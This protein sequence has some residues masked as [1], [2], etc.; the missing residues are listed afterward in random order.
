MVIGEGHQLLERKLRWLIIM[1]E[2][3]TLLVMQ[4]WWRYLCYFNSII[5]GRFQIMFPCFK[6]LWHDYDRTGNMSLVHVL[7]C[8]SKWLHQLLLSKHY[9][10]KSIFFFFFSKKIKRLIVYVLEKCYIHRIRTRKCKKK[11][12]PS[13]FALLLFKSPPKLTILY[14]SLFWVKLYNSTKCRLKLIAKE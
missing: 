11:F 7:K 14:V 12:N 9:H 4:V 2:A 1:R 6:I 13:E 5:L 3:W 8:L 10:F